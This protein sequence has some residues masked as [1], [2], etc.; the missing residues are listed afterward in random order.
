M[1]REKNAR[2][3]CDCCGGAVAY[4]DHEPPHNIN[5]LVTTN[6]LIERVRDGRMT[7][8]KGDC[9]LE[10][11]IDWFDAERKYTIVQFLRCESCGNLIFWGLC[12]R[13]APV[14]KVS[15]EESLHNWPWG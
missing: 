12:V 14:Y 1:H 4:T 5:M 6:A 7:R 10:E 9:P 11:M 13:G 3:F 15:D 2:P 8:L